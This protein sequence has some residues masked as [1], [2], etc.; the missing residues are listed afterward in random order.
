MA[1]RRQAVDQGR[2]DQVAEAAADMD[3]DVLMCR[4]LQ[5][6][7]QV[8]HDQTD[9]ALRSRSCPQ[10]SEHVRE[11]RGRRGRTL[12]A[13]CVPSVAE[14]GFRRRGGGV[15]QVAELGGRQRRS[16]DLRRCRSANRTESVFCPVRARA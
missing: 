2:L 3:P 8:V 5:H 7:W 14:T 16:A 10:T 13:R 6:A 15:E 4:D 12:P 11:R 1:S 9:M